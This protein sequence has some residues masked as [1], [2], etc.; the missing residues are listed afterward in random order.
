MAKSGTRGRGRPAAVDQGAA[1]S[2]LIA[3]TIAVLREEGFVGASARAIAARAGFNSAAV[4][5]HFGSVNELLLAALDESSGA[6]LARYR[7]ATSEITDVVELIRTTAALN[8]EDYEAG[9][10]AV[11]AALVGGAAAIPGLGPAIAQRVQPW[12]DLTA[13][14]IDRIANAHQLQRLVNAQAL[15]RAMVSLFLGIELMAQ[16]EGD[17]HNGQALFDEADA[18]LGYVT[19]F[20]AMLRVNP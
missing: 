17:R 12:I 16:L 1:R 2:A 4:F 9:H 18:M 7:E 19:P 13:D 20:L 10:I 8:R 11:M 15:A 14:V 3:A 5:Y 6:R